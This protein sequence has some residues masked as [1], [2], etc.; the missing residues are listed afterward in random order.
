MLCF[1]GEAVEAPG[2]DEADHEGEGGTRENTAGNRTQTVSIT[3][4]LFFYMHEEVML[5][6]DLVVC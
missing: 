5:Q 1:P 4:T 2:G 6:S 3:W